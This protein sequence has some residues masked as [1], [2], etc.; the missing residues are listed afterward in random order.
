MIV[1]QGNK[2][3]VKD[4]TGKQ[5][6]GTHPTHKAALAQLQAIEISKH[7]D[8]FADGGVKSISNSELADIAKRMLANTEPSSK[9]TFSPEEFQK[10]MEGFGVLNEADP[11]IALIGKKIAEKKYSPV[12]G[13]GSGLD[14]DLSNFAAN[15]RGANPHLDVPTLVPGSGEAIKDINKISGKIPVDPTKIV[16]SGSSTPP[17]VTSRVAGITDH[18]DTSPMKV[19]D[20]LKASEEVAQKIAAKKAAGQSLKQASKLAGKKLLGGIP[21]VGGAYQALSTGDAF[22]AVPVVGDLLESEEVGRGS[23]ILQGSS[24]DRPTD[25]GEM[26]PERFKRLTDMLKRR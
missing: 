5:T 17:P 4:H 8:K 20:A 18:I 22:A 9:R 12:P 10:A 7:Q 14:V 6:L 11:R 15:I 16:A 19:K 3:L 25:N 13:M 26:T 1:K 24:Q 21:L 23:D 2:F